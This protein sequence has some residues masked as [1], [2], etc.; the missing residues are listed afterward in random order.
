MTLKKALL[1]LPLLVLVACGGN[2]YQMRRLTSDEGGFTIKAPGVFQESSS[3]QQTEYGVIGTHS[4]QLKFDQVQ[5]HVS[6]MKFPEAAA[7]DLRQKSWIV[8]ELGNRLLGAA[9]GIDPRS[10]DVSDRR[11]VSTPDAYE[12]DRDD[13]TELTIIHPDGRH[14]CVGRVYFNGRGLYV[15]LAVVPK[16]ASYEQRVHSQRFLGSLELAN[17]RP[18][19]ASPW[20]DHGR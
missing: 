3:E 17:T 20:D 2:D 8:S 4:Y 15:A 10:L 11:Q 14:N 9:A 18:S 5:Y 12:S 1:L 7:R 6:Y 13:G 16:D 19:R